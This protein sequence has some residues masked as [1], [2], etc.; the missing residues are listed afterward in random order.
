[1]NEEVIKNLQYRKNLSIAFFSSTNAAVELMKTADGLSID[2]LKAKIVFWRNF[3][4]EEHK[5]YYA[6]NIANLSVNYNAEE[7]MKRLK[8]AENLDQLKAVWISLS[9]DERQDETIRTETQLLKTKL[10]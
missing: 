7:T 9:E 3:F 6:Q 10:S 8:A 1:M 2:E 4:L 5:E